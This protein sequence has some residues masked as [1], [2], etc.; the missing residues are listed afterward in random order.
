MSLEIREQIEALETERDLL[1]GALR[2]LIR[3][4][5]TAG[6]L[7]WTTDEKARF[8]LAEG[9]AERSTVNDIPRSGAE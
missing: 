6:D 5:Y 4:L 7:T 3:K 9:L 1:R 2:F 8:E